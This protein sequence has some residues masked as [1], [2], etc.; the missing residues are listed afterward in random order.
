MGLVNKSQIKKVLKEIDKEGAVSSVGEEVGTEL[1]KKAQE[2]LEKGIE[3]AK[4]NKRKTLQ[5]RDL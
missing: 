2:I 3:R 1:E 4:A 5:G